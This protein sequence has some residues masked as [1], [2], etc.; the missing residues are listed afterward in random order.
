MMSN[1]RRLKVRI[2]MAFHR[3][4]TSCIARLM[5][6][7]FQEMGAFQKCATFLMIPKLYMG[8]LHNSFGVTYGNGN[9]FKSAICLPPPRVPQAR[10]YEYDSLAPGLWERHKRGSGLQ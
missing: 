3:R 5:L 9:P 10:W 7:F 4:N 6:A 1:T 2:L 8:H